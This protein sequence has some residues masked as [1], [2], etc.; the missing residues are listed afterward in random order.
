MRNVGGMFLRDL[1]IILGHMV[2]IIPG[3]IVNYGFRLVPY[4]LSEYP[5]IKPMDALKLSFEKMK[6]YKWKAFVLDLSFIGWDL[7]N[8]CTCGILDIFYVRPYKE[9]ARAEFY[10][11]VKDLTR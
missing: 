11:A 3:I 9:Q 5:D 6:G 8:I 10:L 4:I 2:F 1:F 7:L